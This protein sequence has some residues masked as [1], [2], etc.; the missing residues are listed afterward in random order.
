MAFEEFYK[1]FQVALQTAI[2]NAEEQTHRKLP[3][4]IAIA[5]HGAG[6]SGD[7]MNPLAA[8]KNLYLGDKIFYRIIDISVLKVN[9]L[10]TTLFVRASSHT[11][12]T[13]DQTWNNPPGNGPFKQLLSNEIKIDD[14]EE[15]VQSD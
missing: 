5:L 2:T 10:K 8:A 11:P 1:L 7:L 4:D 9:K 6:H 13:F 14:S 15:S 3:T 12:S